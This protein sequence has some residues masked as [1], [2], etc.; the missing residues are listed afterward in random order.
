MQ[1]IKRADHNLY[2]TSELI[3]TVTGDILVR[4]FKGVGELKNKW[5]S[6]QRNYASDIIPFN[7]F[8][9]AQKALN[10]EYPLFDAE[11]ISYHERTKEIRFENCPDFDK[12]DEPIIKSC[13]IYSPKTKK[14]KYQGYGRKIRHKWLYVK[15]DYVGFNVKK[16]YDRSKQEVG[17]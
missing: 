14:L 12:D 10:E 15:D 17:I 7:E 1:L 11:C 13:I 2:D 3:E 6:V 9:E 8:L 5:V 16:S 4:Y